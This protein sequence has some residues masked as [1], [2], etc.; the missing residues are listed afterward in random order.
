VGRSLP[1]RTALLIGALIPAA[2]IP[3]FAEGTTAIIYGDG[4]AYQVTSP[5]GWVLDTESGAADGL[6]PVFY[7][8]GRTWA[9]APAVIYVHSMEREPDAKLDEV[10]ASETENFKHEA[11]GHPLVRVAPAVELES[12]AHV[13]VRLFSGDRFGNH[14]A[15]AYVDAPNTV[16]LVVLTAHQQSDFDAALPAFRA[17]VRSWRVT[18]PEQKAAVSP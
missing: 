1:F 8:Q 17:L 15:V 13:P 3:A 2:A 12:G 11:G 9:N 7:P 18:A 5:A 6:K 14:E 4:F 10:I 16:G